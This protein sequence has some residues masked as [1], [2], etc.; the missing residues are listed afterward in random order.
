MVDRQYEHSNVE[1]TIKRKVVNIRT[2]NATSP[3]ALTKTKIQ[4]QTPKCHF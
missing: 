3:G 1:Q 4:R 2:G